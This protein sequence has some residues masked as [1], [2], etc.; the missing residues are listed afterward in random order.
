MTKTEFQIKRKEY[1]EAEDFESYYRENKDFCDLTCEIMNIEEN[2]D[3]E[4]M[5][6]MSP[7]GYEIELDDIAKK[8]VMG[9]LYQLKARKIMEFEI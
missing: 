2:L 7:N 5:S 8:Q 1:E 3:E 4:L 6:V 9:A